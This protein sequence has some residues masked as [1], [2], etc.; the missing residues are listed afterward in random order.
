MDH[1][2]VVVKFVLRL[3][4]IRKTIRQTQWDY[5]EPEQFQVKLCNWFAILAELE[6]YESEGSGGME[7]IWCIMRDTIR[8][9]SKGYS[10]SEAKK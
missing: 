3:Q 6:A 10:T 5:S 7:F 4:R 8:E 2:L 9:C 1:I